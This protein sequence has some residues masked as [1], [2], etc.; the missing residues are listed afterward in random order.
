[1]FYSYNSCFYFILPLKVT[2][3]KVEVWFKLVI[4]LKLLNP[5]EDNN[6]LVRLLMDFIVLDIV[7]KLNS[8]DKKIEDIWAFERVLTELKIFVDIKKTFFFYL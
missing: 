3:L 4:P 8:K 7:N 5:A 6:N 2:I 1:M